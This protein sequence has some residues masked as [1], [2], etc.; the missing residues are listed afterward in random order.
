MNILNNDERHS[1]LDPS[2]AAEA[3]HR[4]ANSFAAVA[5]AVRL[6]A[7]D[8]A[9]VR[10]LRSPR[11]VRDLLEEVAHRIE[12]AATLHR[13]LAHAEPCSNVELSTYLLTVARG[14]VE[15]S[16]TD[17]ATLESELRPGCVL[18]PGDALAV[19]MV[20][21][22]M[23]TNALKYAHPT[24]V[25]GRIVVG[26][27]PVQAGVLIYVADDG[28][29]LPEGLSPATAS[30]MGFRLIH[31]LARQIGAQ[32][33]IVEPGIGVRIELILKAGLARGAP[34]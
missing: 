30:S 17:R 33:R 6:Q 26:C 28:V 34:Q 11:E 19:A 12:T 23:V 32:V 29:G 14:V 16:W 13:I 1:R 22:E 15:A 21:S 3:N 8:D 5:A 7:H 20:V 10:R 27:R 18:A 4:V 31:A 25:S 9:R 2:L 24:G